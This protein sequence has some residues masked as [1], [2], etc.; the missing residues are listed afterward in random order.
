MKIL[1]TNDDGIKSIGLK[2]LIETLQ[3]LGHEVTVIA[4][5]KDMSGRSMSKTIDDSLNCTKTPFPKTPLAFACNGT[6]VDCVMWGMEKWLDEINLVISGVNLGLNIATDIFYSATVGG[7]IEA[8][9]SQKPAMALSA[10][11]HGDKENISE[12]N[13]RHFLNKHLSKYINETLK[14][15]EDANLSLLNINIP[16]SPVIG[17]TNTSPHKGEI[18][19]LPSYHNH[20]RTDA[21]KQ[22]HFKQFKKGSDAWAVSKGLIS[23]SKIFPYNLMN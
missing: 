10:Q 8:V 12:S 21:S 9:L 2:L 13:V 14:H 17:I 6:T 16:Y 22:N 1:V 4:P 5:D 3:T 23:V 20:S 15:G 18:I 19:Q 11:F 7:A